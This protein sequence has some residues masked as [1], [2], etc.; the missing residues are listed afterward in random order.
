MHDAELHPEAASAQASP[1]AT[2]SISSSPSSTALDQAS[3][4]MHTLRVTDSDEST[5]L[6]PATPYS[7]EAAYP[8]VPPT[9]PSSA[10]ATPSS[11]AMPMVGWS[12]PMAASMPYMMAIPG[13]GQSPLPLAYPNYAAPGTS[14]DFAM[15]TAAMATTGMVPVGRTVYIGNMPPDV[16]AE[17]LLD[18]VHFGPIESVRLLPEKNCAFVSFLSG[19]VAAAFHA[20][21]SVRRISLRNRELKIGWGKPSVPPPAVMYA[22]QHHNASRNV[23]FGQLDD[24]VTEDILRSTLSKYGPIDQIKLIR[25]QR[26]AFVHFLSIQAAMKVVSSLP[27]DTEWSKYRINYGKDRCA[28]VPKGQQQTQAHNHQAAAMGLATAMW[29][30]YPTGYLNYGQVPPGSPFYMDAESSA[31]TDPEA[32]ARFQGQMLG[33]VEP[34]MYQF[35]NRTVYLGNLHPDTTV[36][37]ICNHVRGGILQSIR[38]MPDRHIAFVTFVD[39]NT[40]LT[41]FHMALVSGINV[42]NRRLKIGWGKPTGPLSPAIALAVQS[43]ASRNVY[44]GNISDHALMSEE[45]IRQD[46]SQYGELEMV[47]TLRERNCAFANFTNIQSAIKCI[48]G[49]KYHPDYQSVKVSF[50]KDRCGNPPKYLSRLA[51]NW[52]AQTRAA[53]FPVGQAEEPMAHDASTPHDQHGSSPSPEPL[54]ST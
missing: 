19:Q 15:P 20:D 14:H 9:L 50:G 7:H 35:G 24:S 21:S 30:G 22:V 4:A 49:L 48:E 5:S 54:I 36:E 52:Q 33:Q 47:N 51:M 39:H 18:N 38:Y 42:L 1:H 26:I 31:S 53:P 12:S 11:M 28:Y 23:Y 32:R 44:I 46:L 43:G 8:I 29:L 34:Q 6:L 45:K 2:P 25:E 3:S 40:A 17:E 27:M 13:G 41:F 10:A 37:D 16:S